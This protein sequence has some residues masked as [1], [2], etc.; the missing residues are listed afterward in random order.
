MCN[1]SVLVIF[2]VLR[3]WQMCEN[4]NDVPSNTE[5]SDFDRVFGAAVDCGTQPRDFRSRFRFPV[6]KYWSMRFVSSQSGYNVYHNA[7][8]ILMVAISSTVWASN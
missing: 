4:I 8:N 7:L 5:A 1:R 2:C 6:H 3:D